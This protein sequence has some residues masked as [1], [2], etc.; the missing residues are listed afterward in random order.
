MPL[1]S[2]GKS[3]RLVLRPPTPTPRPRRAAAMPASAGG[4]ELL[5]G[6]SLSVTCAAETLVFY[7]LP[8]LLRL[9]FRRCMHLVLAAFL[10]RMLCYA[11]LPYAPTPWLVRRGWRAGRTAVHDG[12]R[13]VSQDAA[14]FT[15]RSLVAACGALLTAAWGLLQPAL[16]CRPLL[17]PG[18]PHRSAARVHLCP[19]LGGR[20]RILPAAGTARPGG[21]IAGALPGCVPTRQCRHRVS[22]VP[23]PCAGAAFHTVQTA[24]SRRT[25]HQHRTASTS[26]PSCPW[27]AGLYFGLGVAAGSAL[28]G[29]V[30]QRLGAQAVYLVAC[31]VLAAGWLLCSLAQLALHLI[32]A[33]RSSGGSGG[34]GGYQQVQMAEPP[35]E[36]ATRKG[37]ANAA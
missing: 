24:H 13:Q 8:R 17:P 5:M 3:G 20:V 2:K 15:M 31:S 21:D 27:L 32:G 28:G 16:P 34:G 4:S 23:Q 12:G 9:G 35:D 14:A 29:Q 18:A 10:L 1:C 33:Q 6:V 30:Y 22:A 7:F 36:G 11:A 37:C 19:G 25:L 26:V